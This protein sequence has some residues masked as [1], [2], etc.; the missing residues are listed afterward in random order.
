MRTDNE[1]GNPENVAPASAHAEHTPAVERGTCYA[2]FAYSIGLSIDLQEAERRINTDKRR[3]TIK[4][5]HRAPQY[6]K[7]DP[8]P[9]RVT[10]ESVRIHVG[11]F[12]SADRLNLVLYDFGAVSVT[13]EIA[14]D[15]P[16]SSLM[17]LSNEL[18]DNPKLLTDSRRRVVELVETIKPAITKPSISDLVEDYAVYELTPGI[19]PH[20]KTTAYRQ[21]LAQILRAERNFLSDQEVD[22]AHACTLSFGRDDTVI[23]DWNAA[24]LFD[25]DGDDVRMV[26]D[27]ANVELLQLRYLDDRLDLALAESYRAVT[28]RGWR[29]P[30]L[31]RSNAND[32]R[33]VAELQLDGAMLFEGV[34]NALKL[35]G[36]QYLA[37]V[38]RAASQRLH[39]GEWDA[40]ILRKLQTL[41]STYEKMSDRQTNRRM[42]VLEWIIIILIA[43]SIALPFVLTVPGY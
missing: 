5:R 16:L 30:F 42:E 3:E 21:E 39:L 32:L 14:V 37:R 15:G 31:G 12:D 26:L 25:R 22:D 27:Y 29:L 8:P 2:V 13:Y 35:L 7:Y 9:L 23:I 40:T 17:A 36:D 18:Y 10:Q 4:H 34:N 6:F 41:E 20:R 19:N 24:V 1:I 33:R 28:K 38:Y 11:P 43:A